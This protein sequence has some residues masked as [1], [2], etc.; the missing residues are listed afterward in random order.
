VQTRFRTYSQA[1][2]L[3]NRIDLRQGSASNAANP[4]ALPQPAATK[5]A[6][7]SVSPDQDQNRFV[8]PTPRHGS[9]ASQHHGDVHRKF[10]SAGQIPVARVLAAD[11][12]PPRMSVPTIITTDDQGVAESDPE[13]SLNTSLASIQLPSKDSKHT[14]DHIA[15]DDEQRPSSYSLLSNSDQSLS[16]KQSAA[17]DLSDIEE[18]RSV[19]S[20]ANVTNLL[21]N[22]TDQSDAWEKWRADVLNWVHAPDDL[23]TQS[24]AVHPIIRT[25]MTPQT[26][27]TASNAP[28]KDAVSTTKR[29]SIPSV[30]SA[31]AEP[32]HQSPLRHSFT[33]AKDSDDPAE[34]AK[35]AAV[36]DALVAQRTQ[37]THSKE[38]FYMDDD[39]EKNFG[40]LG[41]LSSASSQSQKPNRFTTYTKPRRPQLASIESADDT[42]FDDLEKLVQQPTSPSL[43]PNFGRYSSDEQ[44]L[45]AHEDA[46]SDNEQDPEHSS[47]ILQHNTAASNPPASPGMLCLCLLVHF[48]CVL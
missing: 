42:T 27:A 8:P 1:R 14:L 36:S 41:E 11:V 28:T 2:S 40:Y 45:S 20:S 10:A 24:T 9:N 18:A 6:S 5:P 46:H 29:N 23:P 15:E 34:I 26:T 19:W 3:Q 47:A 16:R 31:R 25:T 48:C 39:I 35:A 12:H 30:Q 13:S 44:D 37:S 22:V 38:D 4:L 32:R 7:A 33:K 43:H 21:R 17:T